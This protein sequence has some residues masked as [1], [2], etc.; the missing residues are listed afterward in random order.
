MVAGE[1]YMIKEE[2]HYTLIH[3]RALGISI[4]KRSQQY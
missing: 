3:R 1:I 2:A 4:N